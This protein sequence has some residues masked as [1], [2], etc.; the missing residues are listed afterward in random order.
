MTTER[1][2]PEAKE[3]EVWE[4]REK[5]E[6]YMPE[7]PRP[8]SS[9][10]VQGEA[11]VVVAVAPQPVWPKDYFVGPKGSDGQ[12][13][14]GSLLTLGETVLEIIDWGIS[15]NEGDREILTRREFPSRTVHFFL[16]KTSV[17][18]IIQP[19]ERLR[20]DEDLAHYPTVLRTEELEAVRR[21]LP[22]DPKS[23]PMI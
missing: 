12:K 2:I 16:S 21:L 9:G 10:L 15:A 6:V 1:Q 4:L 13:F 11:C 14:G 20:N 8:V 23:V 7:V 18:F 19:Y 5:A 17:G 3:A 22:P